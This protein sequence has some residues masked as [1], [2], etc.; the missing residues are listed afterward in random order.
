[1]TKAC[2]RSGKRHEILILALVEVSGQL[3]ALAALYPA[4]ESRYTLDGKLG[5]P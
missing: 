1:M 2:M 4:K 5:G 3:H